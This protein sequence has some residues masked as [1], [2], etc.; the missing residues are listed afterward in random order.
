MTID[1]RPLT[2]KDYDDVIKLWEQSEGVGLSSADSLGPIKSY[3]ARNPGLSFVASTGTTIV[4]AVLCGHDGRRGFI[5]HLAVH[6]EYRR[7]GIGKRLV[8][9]CLD[10]LQLNGIQKCHLFVFS[11]NESGISFWKEVNWTE[12]IELTIMSKML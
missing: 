5:H 11:E 12:R 4:G 3:L 8:D 10:Q 7:R 2:L 6:L 1:I 9:N